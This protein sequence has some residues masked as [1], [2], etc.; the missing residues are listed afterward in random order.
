MKK[1]ILIGV[2]VIVVIIVVV[3]VVG[4]SK[5]G[6]VIKNVVNTYGPEMTKTDVR[7]GDVKVS[8]FS[9]KAE[10]KDFY[11]G[12]P[13]GFKSA[14]AMKVDSIYVDVDEKSLVGDTI[15]IERIEVIGPDITYEKGR[16]TDN[17]QTILN[18]VKKSVGAG[19]GASA[20]QTK[21]GDS[22]KKIIIKDFIVKD[23]KVKLAMAMLGGKG[24]SAPLP[25]IHLKNIG[26]KKGGASPAEA[27]KEVFSSLYEKIK[28]P[29]VTDTLNKGL[30]SLGKGLETIGGE[31]KK[32]VEAATDKLKGLFGK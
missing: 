26:E 30:K 23:G 9:A 8:V 2:G 32:G 12:N 13:K 4:I 16:G 25:D 10:L 11:L 6:P 28:S 19:G 29:A 22:G 7:L 14:H 18:N 17:F 31:T 1:R 24:I 20:E 3:L 5:L 21:K 27:F 15:I